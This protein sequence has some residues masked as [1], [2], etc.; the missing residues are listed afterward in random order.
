M[1]AVLGG[2]DASNHINL[3]VT[4]G[5]LAGTTELMPVGAN[6]SGLFPGLGW[7][8][9]FRG[10]ALFEGADATG[11]LNLWLTDGTS[12]GTKELTVAEADP[13]ALFYPPTLTSTL[14]LLCSMARSFSGARM[15]ADGKAFGSQTVRRLEPAN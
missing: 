12:A 8:G 1:K 5:T 14:I 10:K 15:E 6:S 7:F 4:D 3:W 2:L 11:H 13:R 9:I